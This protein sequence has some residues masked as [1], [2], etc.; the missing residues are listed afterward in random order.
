[1][2][3]PLGGET[4]Q[5]NEMAA[6]AAAQAAAEL[7]ASRRACVRKEASS[8]LSRALN[9]D[10]SVRLCFL[11]D[12]KWG[13]APRRLALVSARYTVGNPEK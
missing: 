10:C 6:K 2:F 8:N 11:H 4:Q 5:A 9:S 12:C 13:A 3:T 7:Q 1:M